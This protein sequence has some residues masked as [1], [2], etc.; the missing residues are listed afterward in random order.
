MPFET[1]FRRFNKTGAKARLARHLKAAKKVGG[2]SGGLGHGFFMNR[3][4]KAGMRW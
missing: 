2:F 1:R 4:L 3:K